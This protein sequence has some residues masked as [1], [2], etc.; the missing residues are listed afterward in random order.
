MHQFMLKKEMCTCDAKYYTGK[1]I[2][3]N[4]HTGRLV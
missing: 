3:E 4:L 1:F 2:L